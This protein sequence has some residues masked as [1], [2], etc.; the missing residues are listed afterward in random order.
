MLLATIFF[1]LASCSLPALLPNARHFGIGVAVVAAVVIS[2]AIFAVR[3]L[4]ANPSGGD[5]PAFF[6]IVFLFGVALVIIVAS[7]LGRLFA[8]WLTQRLR[9]SGRKWTI[10]VLLTIGLI[11]FLLLALLAASAP[12]PGAPF[13]I[14]LALGLPPLWLC[15]AIALA[16][17]Q[18]GH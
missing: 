12:I 8:R 18:S 4:E 13:G 2:A 9:R 17:N 5:G 1:L 15:A 10:R 14:A 3:D 11:P 7:A 16:P 6:G